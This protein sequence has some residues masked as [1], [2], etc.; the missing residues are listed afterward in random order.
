MVISRTDALPM[1]QGAP[2]AVAKQ[3]TPANLASSSGTL[4]FLRGRG[5][6]QAECDCGTAC[7]TLPVQPN[8]PLPALAGWRSPEVQGAGDATPPSRHGAVGF[9]ALPREPVVTFVGVWR[10]PGTGS[11]ET[12]S[13]GA[14]GPFGVGDF[15]E[16]PDTTAWLPS[17]PGVSRSAPSAP[18]A[19]GDWASSA[20][21]AAFGIGDLGNAPDSASADP[22]LPVQRAAGGRGPGRPRAEQRSRTAG[23]PAANVDAPT[24]Y[25]DGVIVSGG[26]DPWVEEPWPFINI[27]GPNSPNPPDPRGPSD[28]E[29]PQLPHGVSTQGLTPGACP[30]G[31]R[32]HVAGSG[33]T[34]VSADLFFGPGSTVGIADSTAQWTTDDVTLG[35][36]TYLAGSTLR[37]YVFVSGY[38]EASLL[39]AD[40]GETFVVEANPADTTASQLFSGGELVG[41]A[42]SFLEDDGTGTITIWMYG[43]Q[44]TGTLGYATST[45]G[46][47]TF[48]AFASTGVSSGEGLI[49][50]LSVVQ[51]ADGS[52][53][54]YYG[55][56]PATVS[57]SPIGKIYAATS[58]NLA[59][60]TYEGQVMGPGMPAGR[61][62][63]YC[64]QPFALHRAGSRVTLFY[65][66][67]LVE[68]GPD[69]T[70]QIWYSTSADGLTFTAECQLQDDEGQVLPNA[71]AGPTIVRLPDGSLVLFADSSV[72]DMGNPNAA[73]FINRYVIERG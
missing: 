26:D 31:D 64:A 12:V 43:S 68:A 42:E 56:E 36:T 52:Y 46:G 22:R 14:A 73:H 4:A 3:S 57:G 23:H 51:L 37:L 24:V 58:T 7:C 16:V 41:Q 72:V 34:V 15:G 50:G 70:T 48:G 13:A 71:P 49:T 30:V 18:S 59:S 6:V 66:R 25:V 60:W 67:P 9:G 69:D 27:G 32:F 2:Q 19:V 38:G 40:E 10:S 1:W 45:D 21:G 28:G 53:R 61:I 20:T 55:I 33:A 62:S 54:G 5:L 35:D 29:H 8:G 63:D 47:R 17:A 39:S 44:N 65:Y 11:T